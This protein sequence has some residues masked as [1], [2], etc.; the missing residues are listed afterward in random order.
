MHPKN[1]LACENSRA[2]SE[3][4]RLFSQA[5]NSSAV[6]LKQ[7]CYFASPISRSRSSFVD[8][9]ICSFMMLLGGDTMRTTTFAPFVFLLPLRRVDVRL[10]SKPVGNFRPKKMNSKLFLFIFERRNGEISLNRIHY[11]NNRPITNHGTIIDDNC[12]LQAAKRAWTQSR[13]AVVKVMTL[14]S[15]FLPVEIF[16]F[17]RNGEFTFFRLLSCPSRFYPRIRQIDRSN[18]TTR[19]REL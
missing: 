4:G 6:F 18:K 12:M 8:K 14:L 10:S 5:K 2:G 16:R 19:N 17:W 1:S 7:L 3:E 11:K 15:P 9:T 13:S